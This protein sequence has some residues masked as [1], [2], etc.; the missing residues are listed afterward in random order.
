MKEDQDS[1]VLTTSGTFTVADVDASDTHTFKLADS[2][3]VS[4]NSA[5]YAADLSGAELLA[6]NAAIDS[7]LTFND[8][9]K[10]WDFSLD[11][12][13][14]QFLAKDETITITYKVQVVDSA[15]GESATEDITI[16]VTG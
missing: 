3:A 16:T 2:D 11:N 4:S 6:L 10:S 9:A 7:G 12:S 8:A 13:L 5:N 1:S 14:V 15:N